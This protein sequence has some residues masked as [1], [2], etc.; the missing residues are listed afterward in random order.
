[1]SCP[2]TDSCK[3]GITSSMGLNQ[4]VQ[5]RVEAMQIEDP[6][7]KR[8]HIKISGCP[9]G[10]GQHHIANIGFY[11]ASMKVGGRQIPAYI[12]H[13][14]GRYDEGEVQ[15]GQRLKVRLPA[16]RVPEAV[17]RWIRYYEAERQDGEHF[18]DFVDRTG[19]EGFEKVAKDLSLPVEFNLE[20]LQHFI[21]WNRTDPY[22]VE[23][24][25]G[26]CAV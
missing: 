1:M 21:D 2:G 15:Y 23:R 18:N 22:Q 12:A 9:N 5:E 20:N 7:T 8:I 13:V 3:L 25:E 19:A 4:A 11:G 26:E 17:E 14:G 24:G 16:K 6:L 10:C